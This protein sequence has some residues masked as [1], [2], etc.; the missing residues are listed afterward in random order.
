MS[1]DFDFG[2]TSEDEIK[3]TTDKLSGL[4]DL[5]MPLLNNL[6]QNPDK[7]IIKWAGRDRVK[8]IDAFIKKMDEYINS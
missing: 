1:D 8:Q 3:S 5:I 2:F 4:R 7:D 6:K